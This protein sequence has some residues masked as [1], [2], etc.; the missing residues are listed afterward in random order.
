MEADYAAISKLKAAIFI[1]VRDVLYKSAGPQVDALVAAAEARTNEAF[2]L[3]FEGASLEAYTFSFGEY[4]IGWAC[5]DSLSQKLLSNVANNLSSPLNGIMGF[6]TLLK[7]S[8]L[9]SE[10][11]DWLAEIEVSTYTLV[12]EVHNVLDFIKSRYFLIALHPHEFGLTDLV[13]MLRED[14]ASRFTPLDVQITSEAT[15]VLYG[16]LFR[17][18][19]LLYTLLIAV[20]EPGAAAPTLSIARWDASTIAFV[21]A[22]D[23]EA[24]GASQEIAHA[25]VS[26]LCEIMGGVITERGGTITVALP[27]AKVVPQDRAARTER[28]CLLIC[29]SNATRIQYVRWLAEMGVLC[30]PCTRVMEARQ[31]LQIHPI[32][33]ILSNFEIDSS[34]AQFPLPKSK[35][36]L[37][38][39]LRQVN[40]DI[41][42]EYVLLVEDSIVITHDIKRLFLLEKYYLPIIAVQDPHAANVYLKDN[43]GGCQM[44]VLDW[45]IPDAEV[46]TLL[47]NAPA[48]VFK[49]FL[50]PRGRAVPAPFDFHLVIPVTSLSD[51]KPRWDAHIRNRSVGASSGT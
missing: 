37:V 19:Q 6:L 2:M 23:R 49:V 27:L 51:L 32:E 47:F 9:S 34:I 18:R 15:E 33:F 25:L 4:T 31:L 11:I 39:L 10:Q 24:R 48:A 5:C 41:I 36:E 1:R 12:E 50:A 8:D 46:Q 45:T 28:F 7:D 43:A 3:L 42:A 17:I 44:I 35:T 14:L 29:P 16:D 20:N 38:A 40:P 13:Q 22:P 21:I 26:H 30:I